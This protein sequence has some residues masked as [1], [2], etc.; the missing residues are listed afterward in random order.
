[1]WFISTGLLVFN[2][3]MNWRVIESTRKGSNEYLLKQKRFTTKSMLASTQPGDLV[4][5]IVVVSFTLY[6]GLSLW[7]YGKNFS[8][9]M[10]A[11]PCNRWMAMLFGSLQ[12]MALSLLPETVTVFTAD[13]SVVLY[14]L[15]MILLQ[16]EVLLDL[17]KL[18]DY[19]K[20]KAMGV[21]GDSLAGSLR[22]IE[23][24]VMPHEL[25]KADG[26]ALPSWALGDAMLDL[27]VQM[28]AQI[29][30]E[31]L[32]N[33]KAY[34]NPLRGSNRLPDS[35]PSIKPK[36]E[37]GRGA[38]EMLKYMH[39][40]NTQFRTKK[41]KQDEVVCSDDIAVSEGSMVKE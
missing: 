31:E 21:T 2:A 15:T 29:Y 16:R 11:M 19:D 38:I 8:M 24:G 32:A 35:T 39:A 18:M 22:S 27:R 7:N 40:K 10:T 20:N 41:V 6:F 33:V 30:V 37:V 25:G 34:S 1:M 5:Y 13:L 9:K 14:M 23:S 4:Q 3:V 26:G 17:T 36:G 28:R 12:L